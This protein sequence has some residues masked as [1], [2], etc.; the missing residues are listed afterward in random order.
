MMKCSEI[1]LNL[2]ILIC[3]WE[4]HQD[5]CLVPVR[6]IKIGIDEKVDIQ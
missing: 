1:P 4:N 5:W 2:G 3:H 6:D